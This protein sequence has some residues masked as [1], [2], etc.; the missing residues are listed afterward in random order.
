[1]KATEL[2]RLTRQYLIP[3]LPGY[4]AKGP[5]VYHGSTEHL[6]RGFYFERSSH[7]DRG[8]FVW[9]FVQPLYIPSDHL[10]FSFG[11]RL[12]HLAE[13]ADRFWQIRE[14][15]EAEVMDDILRLAEDA[16]LAFLNRF[17]TVESLPDGLVRSF[18]GSLGSRAL[19]AIAYAH[20]LSDSPE[21]AMTALRRL[22]DQVSE[23]SQKLPKRV[24]LHEIGERAQKVEDALGRSSEA[25]KAVLNEWSEETRKAL[26]IG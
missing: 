26:G 19:E 21:K 22:K 6:L 9:V 2:E 20:V 17:P 18:P 1:M 23:A 4:L 10:A 24:W 12:P 5:L 16:G 13:G 25:A 15:G 7:G 14:G 3:R 8:F 11:D